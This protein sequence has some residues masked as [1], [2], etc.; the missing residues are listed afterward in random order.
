VDGADRGSAIF[1]DRQPLRASFGGWPGRPP[2]ISCPAG[3]ISGKSARPASPR[4]GSATGTIAG[5][6]DIRCGS[7]RRIMSARLRRSSIMCHC[8]RAAAG[9]SAIFASVISAA[10][11]TRPIMPPSKRSAC[12]C[13]M[14][15]QRKRRR[16]SGGG[17]WRGGG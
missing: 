9:R 1:T 15:G 11:A 16:P 7:G 5:A 8:R 12:G 17:G 6:A 2:N 3:G 10:I 14:R 13:E 4:S